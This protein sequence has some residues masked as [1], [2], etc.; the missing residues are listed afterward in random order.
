MMKRERKDMQRLEQLKEHDRV[1]SQYALE[2]EC[3]ETVFEWIRDFKDFEIR[4][5]LKQ[6]IATL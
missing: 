1:L 6:Q 3:R 4:E 2:E 5:A